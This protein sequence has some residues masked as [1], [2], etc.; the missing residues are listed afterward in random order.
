MESKISNK[1]NYI[2]FKFY[3]ES[4]KTCKDEL[5]QKKQLNKILCENRKNNRNLV[6][7]VMDVNNLYEQFLVFNENKEKSNKLMNS[8]I[9]Q[10]IVKQPN[11]RSKDI[12]QFYKFYNELLSQGKFGEV[13]LARKLS[14]NGE[15]VAVRSS[16]KLE[17]SSEDI[18]NIYKEMFILNKIQSEKNIIQIQEIYEDDMFIHFVMKHFQ[19]DLFDFTKAYFPLSENVV[20]SIVKKILIAAKSIHEKG[21]FHRDIKPENILVNYD[22]ENENGNINPDKI[23]ICLSDFN[24]SFIKNINEEKQLKNNEFNENKNEFF[25][26]NNKLIGT[27]YYISPEIVNGFFNEMCDVWSIG[28]LTYFLLTFK[29]PFNDRKKDGIFFKIL[30]N[31]IPLEILDGKVSEEAM[32]FIAKTLNK[33]PLKRITIENA[34]KHEWINF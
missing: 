17:L 19:G 9:K 5:L 2:K 30:N 24:S 31:K 33:N 25:L 6:K 18:K 14:E 34:L 22:N 3:T 7:E 11:Y 23:E 10:S 16:L 8:I 28:I 1:K 13:R 29:F 12:R 21:I 4:D 26:T 32:D 20:S 15:K 27:C